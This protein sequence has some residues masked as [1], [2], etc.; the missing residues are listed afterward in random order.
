MPRYRR[1][2]AAGGILLSLSGGLLLGSRATAGTADA[3]PPHLPVTAPE[4]GP[5][6]PARTPTA[7]PCGTHWSRDRVAVADTSHDTLFEVVITPYPD[8]GFA[9]HLPDACR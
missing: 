5:L 2:L 4:R 9:A 7:I 6:G 3:A 1:L 8:P